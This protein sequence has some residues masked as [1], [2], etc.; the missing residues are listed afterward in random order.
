MSDGSKWVPQFTC[1]KS[2]TDGY[3]ESKFYTCAIT[4]DSQTRQVSITGTHDVTYFSS[5]CAVCAITDH[6]T[7]KTTPTIPQNHTFIH[8]RGKGNAWLWQ[9]PRACAYH[10]SI[11]WIETKTGGKIEITK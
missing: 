1:K 2:C 4:F 5:S 11:R 9:I 8:P 10:G 6:T 3:C 7:S